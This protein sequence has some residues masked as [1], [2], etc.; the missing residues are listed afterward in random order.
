M[1][2]GGRPAIYGLSGP[3]LEQKQPGPK[4]GPFWDTWPRKL[5]SSCGIA[6]HEQY[7]YVAMNLQGNKR[8]DWGHEREWRWAD[9]ADACSCPG[10]PLWLCGEPHRFSRVMIVVPTQEEAAQVLDTLKVLHDAGAHN[11][12]HEY[13]RQTLAATQ[14]VALEVVAGAVPPDKLLTIRLE[15]IPASSIQTFASPSATS[16]FK[17]HVITVLAEAHQAAEAAV[18]QFYKGAK[19]DSQGHILDACGFAHLVLYSPQSELA[20]ALRELGEATVIGGV[21]YW[22]SDFGD[23]GTPS[24]SQA[25]AA[26][27]A[28]L[29]VM[30]KAFP[31]ENFGMTSRLD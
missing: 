9:V 28:A 11:F 4:S 1:P 19:K 8:I 21:G 12:G 13:N 16:E 15:D 24:I 2:P 25:E 23:H 22:V 5:A 6:E 18:Q 17:A 30:K 3:H 27:E 20:T 26:V 29:E 10:L 31:M 7:R 14:V